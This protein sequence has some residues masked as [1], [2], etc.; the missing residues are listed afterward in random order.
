LAATPSLLAAHAVLTRRLDARAGTR[1]GVGARGVG[2]GAFPDGGARLTA[3]AQVQEQDGGG[4]EVACREHD[5]H[6][7]EHRAHLLDQAQSREP[8]ER[9]SISAARQLPLRLTPYPGPCYWEGILV[10]RVLSG[11]ACRYFEWAGIGAPRHL[12]LAA[13]PRAKASG[14]SSA[15]SSAMSLGSSIAS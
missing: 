6:G 13:P 2:S 3:E 7:K 9:A 4:E 15:A 1:R 8:L 5:E 10:R 12:W 14:R 11:A